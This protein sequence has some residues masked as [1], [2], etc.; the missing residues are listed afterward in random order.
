VVVMIHFATGGEGVLHGGG[1]QATAAANREGSG[2]LAFSQRKERREWASAGLKGGGVGLG[3]PIGQGLGRGKAAQEEGRGDG[4][5]EGG[6]PEE[7]EEGAGRP[8]GE[9]GQALAGW[10]EVSWA[11]R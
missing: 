6:G 1:E 4:S 9:G 2:G 11:K 5:G 3:W 10:V 7:G 8:G